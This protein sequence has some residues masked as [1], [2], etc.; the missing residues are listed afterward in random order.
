MIQSCIIARSEVTGKIQNGVFTPNM[1]TLLAVRAKL[2]TYYD[3]ALRVIA[4]L[5]AGSAVG[6]PDFV[7]LAIQI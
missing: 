6:V 4:E 2:T 5:S 3:E 7:V 1:Q